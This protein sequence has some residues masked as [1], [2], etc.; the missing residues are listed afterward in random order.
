M[1]VKLVSSIAWKGEHQEAGRPLEVSDAD[2]A[3]LISR[4]RAVAWTEAN[5]VDADNRAAKPK[6]TRKKAAK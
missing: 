4:G 6:A 1:K 5:E 3:W 2:G